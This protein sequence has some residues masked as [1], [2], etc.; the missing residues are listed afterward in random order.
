MTDSDLSPRPDTTTRPPLLSSPVRAWTLLLLVFLAV[1][2]AALFTPALLDDADATHAQ[3]AQHIALT[4]DWVTL[5]VN[6]IRYLEK[7]PLPYWMAAVDYHLFGFNVFATHLPMSLAVLACAILAWFWARRAWGDRA[8]FYAALAILTSLGI[9]LYTRFFIPE[10]LLT[11]FLALALYCFFTGIEDR[12]PARFYLAYG[13]LAIALL[14]KGL[15]APVFF[16]AAIVP[17]LAITGDW[18]R[19]REF[20]LFTGLL[21]FLAIGAPWHILAG[22]RNPDHGNPVG[23]VPTPGH[24]HGF[25]YFYFVNEHF[26]RFLG[27]RYPHD[28]NKQPWFAFWLGQLVWLFPW[29]LFLPVAIRR[30]WRNRRI[31]A[32]DLRYDSTNT[33]QYLDPKLSA[34][35]ASTMA[36]RL[37]FRARTSL[38]LL[39]YAGFILI[40][41]A[42]STNQEYYTWP[43]WFAILLLTAGSLSAI[44]EAPE[45]A[46]GRVTGSSR[47]L[48]GAQAFF[49]FIGIVSAAAL[50][51]GLWT[52]RHLPYVHDIGTLLAHRAVGNYSLSTSHFFD[53]TGPSFAA[54]RLPAALAAIALFLGPL[55]AWRLRRRGHSF[56]STV[57]VAF[58][59]AVFLVAAHLAFARFQPMLSSRA[60]ADTINHITAEPGQQNAQVILY[61][62]QAN[63]SSIIFYTRRQALLVNG[64]TTSMIWG[65]DYPDAPHIFLDDADL[66]S[67]WG[68][69][70]RKFLFVPADFHDHVKSLLGSRL[71]ELQEVSDKTL[72]T[73]RPLN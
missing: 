22:L 19:W 48:T 69:G 35:E 20:R 3:A 60:M 72:Y 71:H 43:A 63:G 23:N 40:F 8:A 56:E 5:Y 49:A 21:L 67:T 68:T 33:I 53:L 59:A 11:F 18:R 39:L 70:E 61:G 27:K 2:F 25:F 44:E 41:F 4:G 57:T 50:A 16:V 14:A 7:P 37:R 1:H 42:I 73:D 6:G 12:K 47:W 9:F 17:Y 24:V 31:F 52:S 34:W 29:S 32:S 54:L 36:A 10:S 62:D 64:R 58:T 13:S 51:Y 66:E 45:S 26:L 30:A 65:S 55:V 28:Y 38:L 15:I 46:P